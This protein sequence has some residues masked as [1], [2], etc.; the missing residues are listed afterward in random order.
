MTFL[1]FAAAAGA[2][3]VSGGP[4]RKVSSN[5]R[6]QEADEQCRGQLGGGGLEGSE[7][8]V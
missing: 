6:H 7:V 8:S 4:S 2:S 1:L 5:D 3:G